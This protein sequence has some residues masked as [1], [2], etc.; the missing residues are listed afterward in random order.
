MSCRACFKCQVADALLEPETGVTNITEL[1]DTLPE[2]LMTLI[3]HRRKLNN[4]HDEN[5][6]LLYICHQYD[7]T[8][9]PEN[10][11][12]MEVAVIAQATITNMETKKPAIGEV[13]Q[14]QAS[15]GER[16]DCAQA[17]GFPAS[18]FKYVRNGV[19]VRQAPVHVAL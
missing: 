7:D 13:R 19:L 10:S 8:A 6:D 15:D 1:D 9:K 11:T 14:G 16:Q 5:P 18:I 17:V 12:L 2:M 3:D 4:D